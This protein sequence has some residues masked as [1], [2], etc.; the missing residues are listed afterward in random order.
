MNHGVWVGNNIFQENR[1]LILGESH[2]GDEN[3]TN[4]KIGEPVPYETREVIQE[5]L[6]NRI[7]GIAYEKW[8]R[9]FDLIA[10]SFGY[11]PDSSEEFYNKIWFGNYVPVLCGVKSGNRAAEYITKYR[12]DYNN[13]LFKYVNVYKINTIICFSKS[14]YWNLP[15]GFKDETA[16]DFILGFIGKRKNIVN[17]HKYRGNVKHDACDIVLEMPLTVYGIKHPSSAGG[18]NADQVY[19]FLSERIAIRG[20]CKYKNGGN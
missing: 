20:L 13:E 10:E 9:F 7:L 3:N 8:Y 6:T 2:Y 14:V 16:E 18:Y 4:D 17:I 19:K 15:S 1:T 12:L 5:Y 11:S